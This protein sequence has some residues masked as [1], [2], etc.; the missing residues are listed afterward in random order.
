ML[1]CK[2]GPARLRPHRAVQRRLGQ[3]LTNVGANVDYERPVP[4]FYKLRAD[5]TVQEEILDLVVTFPGD[6]CYQAIYVSIRAPQASR[7][8]DTA[9]RAGIPSA[10]GSLEKVRRYGTDVLPIVFEPGGR[11]SDDGLAALQ[12]LSAAAASS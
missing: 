10:A 8:S 3:L 7:Y 12:K 9:A 5:G 11:L 1:L 6:V 2:A 4:D